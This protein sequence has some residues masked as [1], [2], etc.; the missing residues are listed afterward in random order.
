ML[1]RLT[2]ASLMIL[3][4]LPGAAPGGAVVVSR[5]SHIDIIGFAGEQSFED[6]DEFTDTGTYDNRLYDELLPDPSN[7]TTAEASQN[8]TV[9]VGDAGITGSAR[10]FTAA[11]LSELPDTTGLTSQAV[12]NFILV[13]DVADSPVTFSLAGNMSSTLSTT[14]HVA[15]AREGTADPLFQRMIGIDEHDEVLTYDFNLA[16]TPGRYELAAQIS[17]TG[18]TT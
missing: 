15:L 12:S 1:A 17:A 16:L 10:A 11:K 5:L 4:A 6:S 9:D 2:T 13:F 14:A 8:S 7:P 18:T 3:F